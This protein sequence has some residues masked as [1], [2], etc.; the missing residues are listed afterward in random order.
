[1]TQNADQNVDQ[2]QRAFRNLGYAFDMGKG[3]RMWNTIWLMQFGY[4][5]N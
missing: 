3:G 1:L 5:I 4:D 2:K